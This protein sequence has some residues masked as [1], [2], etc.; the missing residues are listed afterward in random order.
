MPK[1]EEFDPRQYHISIQRI[2][3]EQRIFAGVHRGPIAPLLQGEI[4]ERALVTDAGEQLSAEQ[5]RA[6]YADHRNR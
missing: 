1:T 2:D 5:R 6:A 3:T 4:L